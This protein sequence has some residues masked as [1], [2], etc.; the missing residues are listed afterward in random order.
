MPPQNSRAPQRDGDEIIFFMRI[1]SDVCFL[2]G[3]SC[4]LY[5]Y[6]YADRPGL[7]GSPRH[8]RRPRLSFTG[9]RPSLTSFSHKV[10][11]ERKNET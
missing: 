3:V 2:H 11:R 4:G 5:V 7:P 8:S 6:I 9:K 1:E 10:W